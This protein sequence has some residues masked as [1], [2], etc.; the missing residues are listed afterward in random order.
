MNMPKNFTPPITLEEYRR[1]AATGTLTKHEHANMIATMKALKASM[2]A[3][4][5]ELNPELND[6]SANTHSRKIQAKELSA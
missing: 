4:A 3:T 5:A 1:R 6:L 2:K